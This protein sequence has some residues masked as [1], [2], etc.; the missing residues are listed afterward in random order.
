LFSGIFGQFGN[1][2]HSKAEISIGKIE[3][4]GI[5]KIGMQRVLNRAIYEFC[6]VGTVYRQ[7]V[8]STK[9]SKAD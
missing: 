3:T 8:L 2:L 4:E 1:K 9:Q 6:L 7:G 5:V